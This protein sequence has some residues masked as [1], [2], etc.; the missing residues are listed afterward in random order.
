M[1]RAVLLA[2]VTTLPVVSASAADNRLSME[3]MMDNVARNG[4]HFRLA[5]AQAAAT[6]LVVADFCPGVVVNCGKVYQFTQE[7]LRPPFPEEEAEIREKFK[8][9][10]GAACRLAF[11]LYGPA[12]SNIPGLLSR[13]PAGTFLQEWHARVR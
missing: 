4:Q 7:T 5:A 2:A 13:P 3:Q 11:E 10:R 8:E 12:G 1:I 9:D 6:G